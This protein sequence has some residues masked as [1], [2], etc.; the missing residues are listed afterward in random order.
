MGRYDEAAPLFR[1]GLAQLAN[2]ADGAVLLGRLEAGAN[3]DE[4]RA[5]YRDMSAKCAHALGR[6]RDA[7][8]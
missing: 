2:C 6:R 5:R 7:A 1:D 3:L 4:S 8:S